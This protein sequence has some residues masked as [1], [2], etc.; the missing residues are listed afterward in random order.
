MIY[1]D[2]EKDIAG[3]AGDILI[4]V[5]TIT[6]CHSLT[7]TK[8]KYCLSIFGYRSRDFLTGRSTKTV[9]YRNRFV[10]L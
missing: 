6:D 4:I 10:Q 1:T 3:L 9:Q 7:F 2:N 8:S 5:S